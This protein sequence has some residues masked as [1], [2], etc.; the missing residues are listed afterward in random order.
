MSFAN[1]VLKQRGSWEG[2]LAPQEQFDIS[3]CSMLPCNEHYITLQIVQNRSN[4]TFFAFPWSKEA[5]L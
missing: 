3:L 5:G 2:C 4:K 1:K